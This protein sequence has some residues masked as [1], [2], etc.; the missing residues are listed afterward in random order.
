MVEGEDIDNA[1]ALAIYVEKLS[2]TFGDYRQRHLTSQVYEL[3]KQNCFYDLILCCKSGNYTTA[4]QDLK[5]KPIGEIL[6]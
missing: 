1:K 5:L 2:R 3:G 6:T 4:W